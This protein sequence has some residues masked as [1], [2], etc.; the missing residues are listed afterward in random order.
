MALDHLGPVHNNLKTTK[1][2]GGSKGT[3]LDLDSI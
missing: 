1:K 2:N 3:D